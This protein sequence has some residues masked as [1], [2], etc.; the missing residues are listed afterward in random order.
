MDLP[1]LDLSLFTKG[2]GEERVK[3]AEKIAE[4]FRSHGFV[5]L[6]NHGIPEETVKAYMGAV[7]LTCPSFFF[8]HLPPLPLIFSQL[9]SSDGETT[10]G[11]TRQ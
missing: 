8:L 7:S 9:A 5:K 10:N 1:T 3:C 6:T 4:S 2:T 11:L